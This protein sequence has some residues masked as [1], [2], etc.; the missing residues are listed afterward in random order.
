MRPPRNIEIGSQ[1][2]NLTVLNTAGWRRYRDVTKRMFTCR[3]VCG[4]VKEYQANNVLG[5]NSTSCGCIARQ[6]AVQALKARK[7]PGIETNLHQLYRTYQLKARKRQLPFE[8]AKDEFFRLT[9][10]PCHYC[11]DTLSN[12][13]EL[14]YSRGSHAGEPR[15]GDGFAYNGIDRVDSSQG[16]TLS[17]CV[18]AC[19]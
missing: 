2:G 4:S 11:G 5:G 12:Y 7:R 17:N 19:V 13:F 10:K 14:R 6:R 15:C 18:P 9:Q 1:F 3:C 8:L 16:Y